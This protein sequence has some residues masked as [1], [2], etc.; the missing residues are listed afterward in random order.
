MN[1]RVNMCFSCKHSV[2]PKGKSREQLAYMEGPGYCTYPEVTVP[3]SMVGPKSDRYRIDVK[4]APYSEDSYMCPC[5]EESQTAVPR[6][7]TKAE[8]VEVE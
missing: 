3:D 5:W 2:W 1:N 6:R 4:G 7:Y 8:W